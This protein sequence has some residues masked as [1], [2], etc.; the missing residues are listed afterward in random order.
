MLTWKKCDIYSSREVSLHA[1]TT[2]GW[3]EMNE[4]SRPT[5]TSNPREPGSESTGLE[6]KPTTM[7]AAFRSTRAILLACVLCLAV[8]H[9]PWAPTYSSLLL[10]PMLT[11]L[12]P[13][14]IP[15]AGRTR[16]ERPGHV[17]APAPYQGH[18]AHAGLT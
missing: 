14:S 3:L 7:V 2:L 8:R 12:S 6:K 16:R 5:V 18:E 17:I 1:D 15:V 13:T 9:P 4:G 10:I 11:S